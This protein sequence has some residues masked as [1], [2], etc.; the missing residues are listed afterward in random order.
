MCLDTKGDRPGAPR[1]SRCACNKAP[2]RRVFNGSLKRGA[3]PSSSFL[4]I[5]GSPPGE[6]KTLRKNLARM[7]QCMRHFYGPCTKC[8]RAPAEPPLCR[9]PKAQNCGPIHKAKPKAILSHLVAWRHY[10]GH[11]RDMPFP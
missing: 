1:Y 10:A 7:L 5:N 2:A 4:N 11:K 9:V 6:R 8:M 3:Y